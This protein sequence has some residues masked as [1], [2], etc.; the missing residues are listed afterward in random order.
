LGLLTIASMP[1]PLE[2]RLGYEREKTEDPDYM[3]PI[4]PYH[5]SDCPARPAEKYRRCT[6]L[7][8]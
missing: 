1:R 8:G 6:N 5:G 7:P 2:Y 3:G 4:W